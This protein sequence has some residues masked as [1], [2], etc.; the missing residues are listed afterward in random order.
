MIKLDLCY[1]NYAQSICECECEFCSSGKATLCHKNIECL[2]H[3]PNKDLKV[4]SKHVEDNLD[5]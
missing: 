4:F 1:S 2:L 3:C 5:D